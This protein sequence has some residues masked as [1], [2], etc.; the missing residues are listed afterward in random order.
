[1][2]SGLFDIALGLFFATGVISVRGSPLPIY[3]I[4]FIIGFIYLA[5]GIAIGIAKKR[6]SPPPDSLNKDG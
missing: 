2:L 6:K 4:C 3:I 1:V 5:A